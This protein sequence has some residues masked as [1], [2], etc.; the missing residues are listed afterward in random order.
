MARLAGSV[1]GGMLAEGSRQLRDGKPLKARDMLLTPAN[2]RRVADQLA[3]MRGAAMKVGQMLSM[4]TGDFLPPELADILARLRDDA[5]IMPPEQLEQAMTESFGA[6][7]ESLFYNFD[8]KPIAAASIGQVHRTLS[9]DGRDIVL[10]VQYPGVARSIDSDVDN[11]SGLL[12]LSGLLPDGLDINPLLADAKRQLKDEADYLKE[13]KHLQSFGQLLASDD[14]FVVP[15]LLPDLTH[16][17]VLAMT[18]VSG[19]PIEEVAV[20][21]QHERNRVTEAMFDLMFL[22]LF[23]LRQMQTDPNFA[24]YR[25]RRKTGEIVLLDF[26]AT[27]RF[28]AE[29]VRSYKKLAAAAVDADLD[30]MVAAAIKLGYDMGEEE[31]PYRALIEELFELALEPV[32]YD[33]EFDFAESELASNIAELGEKVTD[34][35]DF[36][37]MPPMD[38]VYLHR[39]LGGMFMLATRLRARV[40]LHAVITRWLGR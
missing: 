28:K 1:A 7:W 16:K 3:G 23:E 21:P 35:R 27:R 34:Y 9:P 26:G 14:R 31:S 10:K 40:N 8:P 20:A 32:T 38:A 17:T 12:R 11:I 15:E 2:A 33:D 6:D 29:F 18:Y 4:D 5:N 24:N 36:W 13:A 19:V 37:R 22:E 25:Y 39:K 30:G